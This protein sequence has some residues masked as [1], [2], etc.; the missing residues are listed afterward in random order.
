MSASK[1]SATTF[2]SDAEPPAGVP[3]AGRRSKTG[4][5]PAGPGAIV[6]GFFG[7]AGEAAA[8]GGVG[9]GAGGG[10]VPPPHPA[11]AP[12]S[13]TPATVSV[14]IFRAVVITHGKYPI[15]RLYPLSG[16]LV[17][18]SQRHGPLTANVVPGV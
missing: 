11:R 14:V 8:A 6:G 13:N 15:V 16:D 7:G 5:R 2:S 12:P 17:S 1:E 10:G 9:T 3:V 4:V 18:W